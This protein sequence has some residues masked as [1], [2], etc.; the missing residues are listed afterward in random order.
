MSVE[1]SVKKCVPALRSWNS[2]DFSY[3]AV[4]ANPRNLRELIEVVK[5]RDKYPSPLRVAAHRHSMTPCFAT[6]GT[7]VLLRQFNDIRVDVDARTVTVGANVDMY[8]M[9]NAL[10]LCGMQA[11]VS[12]DIGNATAGSISCSGTKD[13]SL[14]RDGLGQLSSTV[15]EMKWVNPR[16][17]VEVINAERDPEKMYYA[18][19]SNGL[20]GVIFEV[21]FRIQKPVL[22]GYEYAAFPLDRLPGRDEIFGGADGVLGFMTP[23]SNRIVVERRS[24]IAP[25]APISSLSRLKRKARDKYWELGATSLTTLLPFNRFYYVLDKLTAAGFL[26]L[27]LGAERG[28]RAHRDDSMVNFKFK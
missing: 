18:R 24:I 20:F 7:Q 21:T 10:R 14:G 26:S 16:G 19:S 13:S 22:L 27:N 2:A 15:V 8:R 3:P 9:R 11:E 17:E 1:T 12:P 5:D 4:I 25:D 6:T 28:F 23:Y